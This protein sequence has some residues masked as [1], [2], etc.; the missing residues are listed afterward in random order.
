MERI[1]TAIEIPSPGRDIII[2]AGRELLHSIATY[3]V[4]QIL[5]CKTYELW[6]MEN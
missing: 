4:S 2:V 3:I 1:V 5:R 6:I